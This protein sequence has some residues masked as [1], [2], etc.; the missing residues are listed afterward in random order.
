MRRG[1]SGLTAALATALVLTLVVPVLAQH[2]D[3]TISLGRNPEPPACAVNPD[4]VVDIWWDIEH[5]TTPNYVYFS[6][7]EETDPGLILDD[8]TYPGSTGITVNRTW[9][10]PP[11][12][13]DGKYWIRV[14]YWSFEA[15][16]EANAEVTFYVCTD[17]GRIC[18][19]KYGDTNCDGFLTAADAPLEDWWIC[20]DTPLGDTFCKQTGPDGEVCWENI[21]LGDYRV[22]EVLQPGWIALNPDSHDVTLYYYVGVNFFNQNIDDCAS[23]VERSSWGT[24]KGLYR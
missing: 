13:M 22:Y 7:W 11:G 9:T 17:S 19:A 10:V 6:M 23:P 1:I 24:I 12:A 14:E 2:R 18:A 15:G 20:I 5:T 16:N 21:V 4:G 8:E 3:A